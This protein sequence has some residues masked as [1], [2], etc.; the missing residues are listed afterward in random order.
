[1]E[2]FADSL[3]KQGAQV[4]H[5]DWKPMAGSNERLVNILERMRKK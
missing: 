2:S 1:L 5:V 4:I 3:T